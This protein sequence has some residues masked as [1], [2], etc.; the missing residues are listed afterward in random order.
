M[1]NTLLTP[2]M[3]TR[4][5]LRIL[6]Q[7]CNFVTNINTQYDDSF[8][9][10][11]AKIGNTLRI[12]RPI[13]YTTSVGKTMKTG[14]ASKVDSTEQKFTLTVNTQRHVDMQF[15]SN[16]LTMKLDDFSGRHIEPAMARLAA[17]IENDALSMIGGAA[18]AT[19]NTQKGVP[20][21][22]DGGTAVSFANIMA[23]RKVLMDGLAPPS[24]LIALLDTQANVDLV[25]ELKG[26][27]HDG[28]EIKKIYK[29]GR[30]GQAAGFEFYENT[31]MPSH[32]TG[33]EG[34][35]SVYEVDGANQHNNTANEVDVQS[36]VIDTGTNTILAGDQFVINNAANS[37]VAINKVHPESKADTG[38]AQVFTVVGPATSSGSSTIVI[39]PG[40]VTS[41]PRK[42]CTAAPPD[43]GHLVFKGSASTAYKQSLLFHPDAFV[44]ASADLAMPNDVDFKSRQ[45]Y[46]GISMR[47]LRQFDIKT[48]KMLCRLDVLY[49]YRTLY[50]QLAC[51]VLH[52]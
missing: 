30:M 21:Y 14:T 23:G 20:G 34:G 37:A 4:E 47:L 50:R 2:D 45:V 31:L 29:E 40:I 35:L 41:G 18:T 13:E 17:A 19:A 33:A 38:E 26:L 46:D 10:D 22:V 7:K 36:L 11:G 6:H 48:D 25:G 5:A 24:G 8:A 28:P 9:Q 49:G 39:S 3:I 1:A 51:R 27:F 42:N 12:R 43:N 15:S 32:T 44:F 52:T 16:E